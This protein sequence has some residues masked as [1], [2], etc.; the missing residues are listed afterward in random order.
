M[1]EESGDEQ[2]GPSEGT[3]NV[4]GSEPAAQHVGYKNPP[5]ASQFKKGMSGDPKGRPRGRRSFETELREVL[6]AKV[7]SPRAAERARYQ[8]ARQCSC[9]CGRKP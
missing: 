5:V 8:R 6:D 2:D 3:T 9:G 1:A 4:N 7:L